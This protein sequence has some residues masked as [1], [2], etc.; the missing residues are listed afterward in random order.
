MTTPFVCVFLAFLLIW[1]PKPAVMLAIKRAGQAYDNKHPRQQQATLEGYGARAQACHQ[2]Q[3]EGFPMFAAAV[4]V[5]HLADADPRRS[6][7]LAGTYVVARVA[8]TIAYLTN[9]DYLRS[10]I[11]T[12]GL[13]ATFGLFVLGWL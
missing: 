13:L 6:A 7:L 12:I 2:N 8:Y 5:A 10:A 4:F 3:L 1:T 9:A 11:W